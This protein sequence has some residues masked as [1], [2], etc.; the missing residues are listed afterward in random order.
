MIFDNARTDR[1]PC[2]FVVDN[3]EG[4]LKEGGRIGREHRERLGLFERNVN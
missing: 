2:P 4:F 1:D 3:I